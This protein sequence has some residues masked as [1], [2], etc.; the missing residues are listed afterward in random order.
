M[1]LDIAVK[2]CGHCKPWLNMVQFVQAVAQAA[3]EWKFAAWD[4]ER[5]ADILL[6][7]NACPAGCAKIP[8]FGGPAMVVTPNSVDCW[9]VSPEELLS[10]V[11]ARLESVAG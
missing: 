8:P 7:L 4:G 6:V 3:P 11:M 2:Y 9:P 10:A 5:P 1:E